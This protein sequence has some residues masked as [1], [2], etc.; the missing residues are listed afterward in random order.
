MP[1]AEA[2][3]VMPGATDQADR[4]NRK[5]AVRHVTGSL[6]F[7]RY[8]SDPFERRA[9]YATYAPIAREFFALSQPRQL[10]EAAL[11]MTF[12]RAV[13]KHFRWR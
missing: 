3:E 5:N 10:N 4:R 8:T 13:V 2:R 11:R 6:F 9:E 7:A 12:L 1:V